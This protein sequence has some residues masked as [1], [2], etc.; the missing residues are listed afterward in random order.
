ME[1]NKSDE[2]RPKCPAVGSMFPH[3]YLHGVLMQLDYCNSPLTQVVRCNNCLG[4]IS[5]KTSRV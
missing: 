4:E 2:N 1:Q 3:T 5:P